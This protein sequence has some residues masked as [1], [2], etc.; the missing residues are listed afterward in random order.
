MRNDKFV[1]K[2]SNRIR[3][4]DRNKENVTSQAVSNLWIHRQGYVTVRVK[5]STLL[6]ARFGAFKFQTRCTTGGFHSTNSRIALGMRRCKV[7]V[8]RTGIYIGG[9]LRC[10]HF[11]LAATVMPDKNATEVVSRAVWADFRSRQPKLIH[12]TTIYSR[13]TNL[14]LFNNA[15]IWD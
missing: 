13:S 2:G 14:K 15:S 5:S 3:D 6:V 11:M 10:S 7:R 1:H 8:S 12:D 9:N 4:H